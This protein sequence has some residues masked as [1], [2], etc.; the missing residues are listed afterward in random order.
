MGKR[1]CQAV[2]VLRVLLDASGAFETVKAA[3]GPIAEPL[4]WVLTLA[5]A[6][7]AVGQSIEVTQRTGDYVTM[8]REEAEEEEA[9]LANDP[10][11]SATVLGRD[12]F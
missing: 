10:K 12:L 9:R 6:A 8:S 3:L 2:V 1:P 7:Y 4:Y 5:V 11:K